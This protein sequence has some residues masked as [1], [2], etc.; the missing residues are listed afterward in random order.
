MRVENGDNDLDT[1]PE[2][3]TNPFSP[4]RP[5]PGKPTLRQDYLSTQRDNI[6]SLVEPHWYELEWNL[7][8]ARK[9]EQIHLAFD[10]EGF[11][12]NPGPLASLLRPDFELATR[13][14][15]EATRKQLADAN[16]KSY[17][18]SEKYQNQLRSYQDAQR[19]SYSLSPDFE[20]QLR[21]ELERRRQAVRK[22]KSLAVKV[23]EK[24]RESELENKTK[25]TTTPERSAALIALQKCLLKFETDRAADEQ[26][27]NNLEVKIRQITPEARKFAKEN[28]ARQ[29]S[30]HDS[31]E[32]DSR[33]A[34]V[35]QRRIQTTFANQ[36]AYVYRT[37][38][39]GFIRQREYSLTPLRLA[40]AIAG[41]PYISARRSAQRC[42]HIKSGVARSIAYELFEF[43]TGVWKKH[44]GKAGNSLIDAFEKAIRKL[45]KLKIV[46]GHKRPNWFRDH[47]AEK[48]YYLKRALQEPELARLHPRAVPGAIVKDFFTKI[49]YPDSPITAMIAE[50]EKI[51]D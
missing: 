48:W 11:R 26:V 3:E 45:P 15:L 33:S 31:L 22:L 21:E 1:G 36:E 6:L 14:D 32:A 16:R 25:A 50:T 51:T 17:S 29:K 12:L 49:H 41:L 37:E 10:I 8:C 7:R 47:L 40:N 39:L 28:D 44:Q 34:D 5:G 13:K 42:S 18:A 19:I 46:S 23:K 30:L 38:V 27:C 24:L 35:E 20:K 9:P 43:V 4:F 2:S